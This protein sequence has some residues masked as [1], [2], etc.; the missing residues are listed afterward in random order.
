[1]EI[2]STEYVYVPLISNRRVS[3]GKLTAFGLISFA[4]M[5]PAFP[6]VAMIDNQLKLVPA[7]RHAAIET[8]LPHTRHSDLGFRLLQ[9]MFV[10]LAVVLMVLWMA[11]GSFR[12]ANNRNDRAAKCK[13]LEIGGLV[14]APTSETEAQSR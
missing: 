1:M 4:S 3:N 11:G 5:F 2:D 13:S 6:Q 8:H 9:A 14:C 10:G 12:F 7:S